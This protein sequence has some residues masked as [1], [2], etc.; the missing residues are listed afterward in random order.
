MNQDFEYKI[1]YD[2]VD[3]FVILIINGIITL[4]SIRQIAPEVAK[5]CSNYDCQL[6]LNDMRFAKLD[7]SVLD[8]YNSPRVME[9]SGITNKLKR[10]V[11]LP[12]SFKES[13]F[14]EDRSRNRGHHIKVFTNHVDAKN[15][16]LKKKQ[17][18]S[19]W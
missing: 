10:A 11:V 19:T 2:P 18:V 14:L 8:A 7:V 15:W 4:D 3:N 17:D 1:N 12:E 9:N 16:L 13:K 5:F 6:L